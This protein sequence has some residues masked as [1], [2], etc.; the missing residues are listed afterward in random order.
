MCH[1]SN[2]NLVLE[3]AAKLLANLGFNHTPNQV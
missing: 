1:D 2:S 3:Q